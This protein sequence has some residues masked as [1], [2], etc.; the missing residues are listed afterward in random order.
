[1]QTSTKPML[2]RSFQS[3]FND[4][5]SLPFHLAQPFTCFH[6]GSR[7]LDRQQLQSRT[8]RSTPYR[9][10]NPTTLLPEL[11]IPAHEVVGTHRHEDM[12]LASQDV[13]ETFSELTIASGKPS[14]LLRA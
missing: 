6:G 11:P 2:G 4:R 3:G 7:L 13:H 12:G 5:S 10:V 14:Y 1:M 9:R 8:S